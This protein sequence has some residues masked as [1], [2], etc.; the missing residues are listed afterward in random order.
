[1]IGNVPNRAPYSLWSPG[2]YSLNASL[3]KSFPIYDNVKFTFQ[4]DCFNVPN[5]V[6]FGYASTNIDASNFGQTNSGSGNR[7]FQFAGR[8]EF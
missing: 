7:D 4:A 5:K 8:I 2:T 1:M 3:R 6:T